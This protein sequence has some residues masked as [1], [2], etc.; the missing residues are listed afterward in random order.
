[1]SQDFRQRLLTQI[2]IVA[3]GALVAL[4]AIF[5]M[6]SDIVS[7]GAMILA[8][9]SEIIARTRATGALGMLRK[10][11][12]D[13][14]PYQAKLLTVLPAR[15]KLISFSPQLG[16][17]ARAR[18]VN[19]NFGFSGEQAA[20]PDAA[21]AVGFSLSLSGQIPDLIAFLGDFEHTL[22]IA[23]LGSIEL[24][25]GPSVYSLSTDGSVFFR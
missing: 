23:K 5:T 8:N 11:A 21:G 2:G 24:S 25:G 18:G 1:M 7:R 6:Q 20:T 22:Y 19:Y 16:S 4:A 15:D 17:L 14:K 12:E 3:G 9:Q 13:A 10:Q